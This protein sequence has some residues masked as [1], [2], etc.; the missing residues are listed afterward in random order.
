MEVIPLRL[1]TAVLGGAEP[2]RQILVAALP[3]DSNR[4]V[5]LNRMERARQAKL[6]E[7][8]P[9]RLADAHAPTSLREVLEAGPRALQRLRQ[10][11]AYAEK[12]HRRGDLPETLAPR[13]AEIRLLACLPRPSLLRRG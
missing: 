13:L 9:D 8:R 5:D 10:T 1:G 11:L 6:G 2:Q 4:V 3:S 7:G 12:W